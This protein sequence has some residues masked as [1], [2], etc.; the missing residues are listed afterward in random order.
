MAQTGTEAAAVVLK[1]CIDGG[2]VAK[3]LD[4]IAHGVGWVRGLD[5]AFMRKVLV[6]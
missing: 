2:K 4:R 3:E 5:T 1:E 6:G